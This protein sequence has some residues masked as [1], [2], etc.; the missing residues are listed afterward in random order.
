MDFVLAT[1]Q[2]VATTAASEVQF[3]INKSAFAKSA[4]LGRISKPIRVIHNRVQ[5]HI[6]DE[7]CLERVVWESIMVGV[8]EGSEG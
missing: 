2:I 4:S 3:A 7:S 8:G 6:C 5:K 1:R